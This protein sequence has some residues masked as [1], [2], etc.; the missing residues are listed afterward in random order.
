MADLA[1]S[2][3]GLL[4]GLVDELG[5]GDGDAWDGG[6]GAL[7][8]GATTGEGAIA[9]TTLSSKAITAGRRVTKRSTG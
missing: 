5:D 7:D 2:G 6:P 3:D 8:D 4:P 1:A 9:K